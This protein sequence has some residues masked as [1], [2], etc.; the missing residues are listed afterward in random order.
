MSL[1]KSVGESQELSMLKNLPFAPA[2]NHLSTQIVAS[3]NKDSLPIQAH[4]RLYM[5]VM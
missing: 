2:V 4:A 1:N 3:K 5:Q